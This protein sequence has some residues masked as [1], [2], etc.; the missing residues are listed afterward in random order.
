MRDITMKGWSSLRDRYT[1]AGNSKDPAR[2]SHLPYQGQT[3]LLQESQ[4]NSMPVTSNLF[5]LNMIEKS[6]LKKKKNHLKP[7][8]REKVNFS[9]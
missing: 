1:R 7:S 2:G 9:G 4:K 6:W 5:T 8:N 3:V